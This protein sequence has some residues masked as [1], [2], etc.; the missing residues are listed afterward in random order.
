MLWVDILVGIGAALG[1]VGGIPQI[2][3]WLAKPKLEVLSAPK[4]RLSFSYSG[5]IAY[6]QL[7][8]STEREDALITK[9]E[10]TVTHRN[11]DRR[12]LTWGGLE[13]EFTRL[14]LPEAS[15]KYTKPSEVF[16]IKAVTQTLNERA[17][18]FYDQEFDLEGRSKIEVAREHYK[19]LKAQSDN[20]SALMVLTKEFK[21]ATEFFLKDTFWKEGSYD[22]LIRL[23]V[24]RLK[25]PYEQKFRFS[26]SKED[27]VSLQK[28]SEHFESFLRGQ[29]LEEEFKENW[30]WVA[31]NVSPAN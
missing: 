26:L 18:Y 6:W 14:V 4:L 2:L 28:N 23:Y 21:Q 19:Y 5:A 17:I 20:A 24:K 9:V 1:I 11:G 3:K 10:L 16:A 13:E 30:E 25:S 7:A 22:L 29:I 27:I 31:V 12:V 15:L 8:I